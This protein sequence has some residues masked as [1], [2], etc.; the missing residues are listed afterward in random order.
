M[1]L[2]ARMLA[3]IPGWRRR[4][5]LAA[6]PASDARGRGEQPSGVTTA[7]QLTHRGLPISHRSIEPRSGAFADCSRGQPKRPMRSEAIDWAAHAQRPPI[8]RVRVYHR[9][10]DVGVAEQLLHGVIVKC[11]G[12]PREL[13]GVLLHLTDWVLRFLLHAI[14]ES[15]AGSHE[16]QQLRAIHL[17][18]A[19]FRHRE[20][21]E[22]HH[23]G[24][25]A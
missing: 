10:A 25:R 18:P 8:E 5:G 6:R 3:R 11:C 9:R 16:R 22:C 2:C 19:L 12:S 15:D 4:T 21:L 20:E 13:G 23:Q 17:S 1:C 7:Q 14:N 24:L